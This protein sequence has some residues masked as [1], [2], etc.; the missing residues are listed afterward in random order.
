MPTLNIKSTQQ[1]IKIG[2][3]QGEEMF[4]MNVEEVGG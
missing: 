3:H 4:V 2:E 1:A